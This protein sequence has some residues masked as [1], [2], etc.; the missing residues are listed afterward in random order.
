MCKLVEFNILDVLLT[1]YADFDMPI[2]SSC[3][4]LFIVLT[5]YDNVS[6]YFFRYHFLCASLWSKNV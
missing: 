6:Y 3:C 1:G 4:L 5:V 2:L